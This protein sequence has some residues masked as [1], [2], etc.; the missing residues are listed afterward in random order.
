M[1][2]HSHVASSKQLHILVVDDHPVVRKGILAILS[3]GLGSVDVAEASDAAHGLSIIETTRLDLVITDISLPGINGI[4][5]V[6]QSI[7]RWPDL[8]FLVLT[9]H[10]EEL[11]AERALRA[12][13][14]GFVM[15]SEADTELVDAVRKILNGS[16]Y[17][18]NN[19]K[20]QILSNLSDLDQSKT[21]VE[22]LS[23]RELEVYEHIGHGASRGEI[24]SALNVSVKTVDSY[25]SR[26]KDKL[27]LRTTAQLVQHAVQWVQSAK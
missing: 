23:D 12:G 20:T 14:R 24:A 13:A 25:R 1:L 15:K 11:F 16:V 18:T 2:L 4:E 5:F 22:R 21:G 6:K 26:L 19:A 9:R 3:H 10:D 8:R 17:V 7:A 27:D